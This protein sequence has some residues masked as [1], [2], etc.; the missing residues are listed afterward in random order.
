MK[1]TLGLPVGIQVVTR[2]NQDEKCL[3]ILKELET[4]IGY[5]QQLPFN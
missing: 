4:Y 1:G 5:K 2:A 3:S